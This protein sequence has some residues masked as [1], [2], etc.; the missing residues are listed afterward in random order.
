M[1]PMTLAD[2]MET[3]ARGLDALIE[4]ELGELEARG[5]GEAV[6]V[7][8]RARLAAWRQATLAALW[9]KFEEGR[10]FGRD[11]AV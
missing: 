7:A 1:Q 9:M 8:E 6:L 3:A 10:A 5:T 4:K 11:E 2:A